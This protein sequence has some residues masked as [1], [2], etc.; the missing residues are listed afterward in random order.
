MSEQPFSGLS[1]AE[2]ERLHY[3]I[4]E[5]GEVIQAATKVLRHGYESCHPDGGPT[6]RDN[7]TKEIGQV[8][9]A[10][11]MMFLR[12]DYDWDKSCQAQDDKYVELPKYLH[13]NDFTYKELK[14]A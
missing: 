4:E 7:L 11:R 2:Q 13:H 5:C 6:N 3:L 8:F 12:G 9:V 10:T 14:N 1:L